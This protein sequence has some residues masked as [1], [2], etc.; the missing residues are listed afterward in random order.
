MENKKLELKE[1]QQIELDMAKY[2]HKICK[3]N[4]ITYWLDGGTLL[5]AI[6][7]KGFIPWDD[8]MDLAMP[9]ADFEKLLKIVN[10]DNGPYRIICHE[11]TKDYGYSFPKIIDTRTELLDDKFGNSLEKIGVFLDIFLMDG[12][13][14]T[15]GSAKLHYYFTKIFKR[16]IFLSRRHFKMETTAKTV[17]FAVP[18]L[19]CRAMGT[20]RINRIFH[21]LSAKRDFYHSVYV[22]PMGSDIGM[23][24][25][26][27]R[28]M[29]SHTIDVPYEDTELSALAEY[30]TYLTACYGDYMTPPPEDQR[31]SNHSMQAWWKKQA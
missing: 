31:V 25:E 16:M 24:P 5:G 1:M 20:D 3:E 7:H 9:R 18:W 6:R 28:E 23:H 2:V 13:G 8:D 17:V 14:D 27:T 19:I 10:A 30:D 22:A 21:K 4:N 26:F 15:W 11:N 12:A 29:F